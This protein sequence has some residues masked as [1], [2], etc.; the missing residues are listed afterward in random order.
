MCGLFG[1]SSPSD[2]ITAGAE[3]TILGLAWLNT[4]RGSDSAGVAFSTADGISVMKKAGHPAAVFGGALKNAPQ[5][6]TLAGNGIGHTRAAT[7]GAVNTQNAHPFVKGRY[8]FAHNGIIHNHARFGQYSVDSEALIH[9]IKKRDFS[10]FSGYG[11]LLWY[12]REDEVGAFYALVFGGTL[13]QGLKAGALFL[14]SQRD[15]LE[16][17]GVKA[18]SAFADGFLYRIKDG[19][20]IKGGKLEIPMTYTTRTYSNWRDYADD[21]TP[22]TCTCGHSRFMHNRRGECYAPKCGCYADSWGAV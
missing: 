1:Y 22:Q 3:Q 10:D 4:A 5:K 18:V 20:A 11:A 7:T 14:S 2:G 17:M 8:V 13:F 9:G 6:M 21:P 16:A 12:D 19:E 15:H